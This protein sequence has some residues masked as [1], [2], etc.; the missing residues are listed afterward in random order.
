MRRPIALVCLDVDGTLIGASGRVHPRVW[1]AV[2]RAR[3]AGIHLAV[4]S[5]RPGFGITRDIAARVAPAGWHSF[6]NGAS[7]LELGTGHSRSAP[8]PA[9]ALAMLIERARRTGHPLE[10]Y[11]DSAYAIEV[12]TERARRHAALL[13]I[14]LALQPL[15]EFREPVVRAQWLLAHDEAEA[16]L[17]APYPGLDLVASLAPTMADTLFVSLMRHGVDKGMAVRLM[18]AEYGVPLEQ[19]M[20]VGDG[21][22]DAPAMRLAGWSVAPHDAESHARAEAE[23]FVSPADEGG[24]AEAL[25]LALGA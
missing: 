7:I 25:A 23:S 5:G 16:V 24:V 20:Y 3:A 19:V 2:D 21:L 22:N 4:C 8:L 1:D 15:T 11:G 10:L 6:S 12:D 9:E 14:P 17:S 18:S 13:G